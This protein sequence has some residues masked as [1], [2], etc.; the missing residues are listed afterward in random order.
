MKPLGKVAEKRKMT[1]CSDGL[2]IPETGKSTSCFIKGPP[3]AG[4]G[5]AYR[6]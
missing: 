6:S 5:N 1:T 2:G 4:A 3:A